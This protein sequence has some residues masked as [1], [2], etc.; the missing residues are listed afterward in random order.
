MC[1]NTWFI[2]DHSVRV[3]VKHYP[4]YAVRCILKLKMKHIVIDARIR[5][6]STGRP[7]DR[8]LE[9]L[10]QMDKQH[11]YTIILSKEDLWTPSAD[12]F[13]TV[14]TRFP[15]FSFNPLNQLLYAI[16]LY[17]LRAD[18]VYFTL[19]PQQPLLYF[20]KQAT[21]THD[22]VMLKFVR[23]GRLL[24]WLHRLR[25]RGY[26]LLL[27][28]AHRRASQV[29]VPTEFVADEVNK[30][31]LVT[32]RKTTVALEASEPPLNTPAKAPKHPPKE[33]IMYTGSA[34]PHKNLERLIMAF[35]L[36]REQHPRLKLVLVGKREYHSKQLERWASNQPYIKDIIFTGF[37]PD[38]ELKWYY[39][40]ALAYVFPSLNEGFGLPALEAMVHGCPVA[41]SYAACLPE[42][43]GDAAHYF[44]PEDVSDMAER[45]N[46][47]I[48]NESLRKQLVQKGYKNAKRFSWREFSNI[49]LH[50]FNQLLKEK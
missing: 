15:N 35:N 3:N 43:Y 47:V 33:F 4:L 8:L 11:R 48:T 32:N 12:N 27:W 21:L 29:I 31:H 6:A 41:S 44:D 45:I 20:G 14:H 42:V 25:M 40:H 39:E 46:D 37:I 10:Q 2:L 26:R 49:H 28:S 23:A 34:F 22:L 30:Y 38:E 24:E 13:T 50:V 16:Q 19:T 36:L 1:K 5:Q 9:H 17:R 7:V 18:L